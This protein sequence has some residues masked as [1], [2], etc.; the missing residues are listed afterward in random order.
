MHQQYKEFKIMIR[1]T[2]FNGR[3]T[4]IAKLNSEVTVKHHTPERKIDKII[5]TRHTHTFTSMR[6][7]R[8][9]RR[10]ICHSHFS[11]FN[12]RCCGILS[13]LKQY[14]FGFFAICEVLL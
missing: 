6:Q 3:A 5:N 2:G 14:L 10:S 1:L 9:R 4:Y 11:Y 13:I 8:L 12:A 7:H